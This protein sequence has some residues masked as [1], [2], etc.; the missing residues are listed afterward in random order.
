MYNIRGI[1]FGILAILGI[2]AFCCFI[3][4]LEYQVSISDLPVWFKF[5]LLS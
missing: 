4:W 5:F 2:I 1:I 3:V